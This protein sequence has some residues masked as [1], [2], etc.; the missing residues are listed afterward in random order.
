MGRL[1]PAGTGMARYHNIGIQVDAP[2]GFGA[3]DEVEDL[4]ITS[5]GDLSPAGG[6]VPPAAPQGPRKGVE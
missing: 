2:E 5:I 4:E 1:I 6:E 3:E